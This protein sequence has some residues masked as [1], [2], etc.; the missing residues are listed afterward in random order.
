MAPLPD[1]N[2]NHHQAE[3]DAMVLEFYD[4]VDKIEKKTDELLEEAR[5]RVEESKELVQSL[6]PLILQL[7]QRL[8][9]PQQSS[10][11][12]DARQPTVEDNAISRARFQSL[13]KKVQDETATSNEER[14]FFT[15][16]REFFPEGM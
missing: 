15:L 4:T 2:A 16:R 12:D 14:E 8:S 9:S 5:K 11:N 3:F 10:V 7:S 13:T 6:R 1:E